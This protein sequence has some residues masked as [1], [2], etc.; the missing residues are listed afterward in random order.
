MSQKKITP[1]ASFA[2]DSFRNLMRSYGIDRM[3]RDSEY[4]R[5]VRKALQEK[6]DAAA[7]RDAARAAQ[8]AAQPTRNGN[9]PTQS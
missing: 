3:S 9:A 5:D 8:A 1:R 2:G 7:K 4:R 6:R